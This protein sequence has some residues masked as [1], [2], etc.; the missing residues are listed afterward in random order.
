MSINLSLIY[1]LRAFIDIHHN[2]CNYT[3]RQ[4]RDFDNCR[5]LIRWLDFHVQIDR[6]IK[7]SILK[8]QSSCLSL[9]YNVAY[10][11]DGDTKLTFT[12]KT[13]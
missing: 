11:Q 2:K 10:L 13:I 6:K 5:F 4:K 3:C 7:T 8:T 1:Y 9:R 12:P